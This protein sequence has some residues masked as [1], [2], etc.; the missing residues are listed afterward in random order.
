MEKPS[1]PVSRRRHAETL[2]LLGA[3]VLMAYAN[4]FATGF[5]LDNRPLILNDARV[6]SVSLHNLKDILGH[7]YWWPGFESGLF[8]P[9]T[10]L[11]FLLNY[12]V[13][14]GGDQPATYHAVNFLLHVAN[15]FLVY[16]LALRVAR[17]Y[18]PAFFAAA[19]WAL[20][21]IAT[22]AV[23]NII[24]R[25]DELAA[26]G[27]LGA[28][29]AYI[30]VSE[31]T[32]RRRVPWLG[33]MMLATALA[34]FSKENGVI[35]VALVLLYDVSFR[36]RRGSRQFY[37]QAYLYLAIPI[38]AMLGVRWAVLRHSGAMEIP[39]LDNPLSA[40]GLATRWA[41]A[42]RVTGKYLSLL[43]WP[44]TLSF[45]YSYNQI[46]LLNWQSATWQ[47]AAAAAI[48]LGLLLAAVFCYR[49]NRTGF[50][51][52]G[53]SALT[54]L[55][56]TNLLVITGTILAERLLYLPAVGFAGAV[57]IGT[58]WLT[59]RLGLRP[60]VAAVALGAIGVAYGAR[61]YQRNPDWQDD[62][63]LSASAVEACPNSFKTHLGLANALLVKDPG[64]LGGERAIEEA[65]KAAAI[66]DSLPN[67]KIATNIYVVLGAIYVARGDSLARKDTDG[68][69]VPDAGNAQWYSKA[70]E[71][72]LRGAA[73][74]RAQN[75]NHRQ[76]ELARGTPPDKIALAGLPDAYINL[77]TAYLRLGDA[78]HALEAFL[79]GRRLAP[80][81]PLLDSRIAS[82]YLAENKTEEAATALL[83]SFLLNKSPSTLSRLAQLFSKIDGGNCAVV[84]QQGDLSLNRDCPIVERDL[85]NA[86]RDLGTREP[87]CK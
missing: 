47:D 57:S 2:L 72:D 60:I 16:L 85:C 30:R 26:L 83:E 29:L 81:M 82:A 58:Y 45:D 23:T 52:L 80:R 21:P 64:F 40:A 20:H 68:N 19:L 12:A 5:P 53:F 7:Q 54:L 50:F 66:V 86:F 55:P 76:A 17:Q 61:T 74:D 46:P 42:L 79:Y 49:R 4:S 25:A 27:V 8:R 36:I 24:G 18:W 73:V 32:G 87:A 59:H 39:F 67:S 65:E 43:A 48:V 37:W 28:L 10:T 77:G 22:E 31:E 15:A 51:L 38:L 9:V 44:R 13:L 11:S 69:P 1:E 41:T 71:A 6:H 3:L 70:L 33:A 63:T 56:A 14:G 35:V 75:E 78:P 34:V 62:E 84:R